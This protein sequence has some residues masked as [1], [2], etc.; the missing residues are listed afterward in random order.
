[1]VQKLS[2]ILVLVGKTTF[3]NKGVI[4]RACDLEGLIV[5]Q[6]LPIYSYTP[7]SSSFILISS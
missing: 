2:L 6:F 7:E 3:V 4:I 1:M 5:K